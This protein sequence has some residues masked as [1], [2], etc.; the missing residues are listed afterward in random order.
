MRSGSKSVNARRIARSL[1]DERGAAAAE[2]AL[3]LVVLAVILFGI[4]EFGRAYSSYEI[5]VSAA[6]EGARVAAVRGTPEEVVNR[7]VE[8][9]VG[10]PIGPGTPTQDQTCTEDTVGQPVT[11]SWTQALSIQV[12]FL[13]DM[14]QEVLV[15]AVFRCE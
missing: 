9:S 11:V 10:Y 13:P 14:S 6:R 8:A 3:I 5:Y 4:I 12:P 7:V 2:F 1:R 15:E